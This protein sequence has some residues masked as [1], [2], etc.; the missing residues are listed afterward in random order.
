[1]NVCLIGCRRGW[2]FEWVEQRVCIR[3]GVCAF[4]Y[5]VC[6]SFSICENELGL[7][8]CVYRGVCLP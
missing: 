2:A 4:V 5:I 3:L 8:G 6:F 1:M 7:I